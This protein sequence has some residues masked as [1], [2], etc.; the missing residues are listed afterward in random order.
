ML[1]DEKKLRA[2]FIAGPNDEKIDAVA[3]ARW[4]KKHPIRRNPV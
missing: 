4:C 3:I 1:P 2:R